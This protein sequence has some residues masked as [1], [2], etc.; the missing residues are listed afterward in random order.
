MP[1]VEEFHDSTEAQWARG[2]GLCRLNTEMSESWATDDL[3][4][5]RLEA[6]KV[7]EA[8][9][10]EMEYV[11]NKQVWTKITRAEAVRKGWKIVK[12]RWIDINKGDDQ[13]PLY[14]SRVVGKEFN[15]GDMEG[16]FAGTPPLEALRYI[17]HSAATTVE[18]GGE[19]VIMI[20][21]VAR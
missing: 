16:L 13:N 14:R 5:M 7:I 21:D 10:R 4:G 9:A 8:R 3:T 11:R 15:D 6:G 17:V 1:S 18:E 20:N 19:N 12:V 2:G